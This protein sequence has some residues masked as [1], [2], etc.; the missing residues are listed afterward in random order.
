MHLADA[1]NNTRMAVPHLQPVGS[2]FVTSVGTYT[3]AGIDKNANTR[4]RKATG[5]I[6]EVGAWRL[7][8]QTNS[9]VVIGKRALLGVPQGASF[10]IGGHPEVKDEHKE[11]IY[12]VLFERLA[13]PFDQVVA[14]GFNAVC[15]GFAPHEVTL[16]LEDGRIYLRDLSPRPPQ[17]IDTYTVRR[18]SDG[19]FECT[20]R[21]IGDT[22][23]VEIVRYGQ[24]GSDKGWLWWP[25]YGDSGSPF[26]ESFYRPIYWVHSERSDALRYRRMAAQKSAVPMPAILID[27]NASIKP[28]DDDLEDAREAVGKALVHEEGV[29]TLPG[30]V[31][32]IK[33]IFG[34]VDAIEKL[35][36]LKNNCDVEILTLFAAQYA[37]RGAIT[38]H[39][40]NSANESDQS[41]MGAH[42]RM[43][44]QWFASQMQ[45]LI[46]WLIDQTF[47]PQKF[48]PC[49]TFSFEREISAQDF[50][51]SIVKAASVS[52]LITIDDGVRDTVRTKLQLEPVD[53][54]E[55]P[56]ETPADQPT[57]TPIDQSEEMSAC[58][59]GTVHEFADAQRKRPQPGGQNK[60]TGPN[61]REL[62]PLEK[63]V[64]YDRIELT[65]DRSEA[66]IKLALM[67]ARRDV[68]EYLR[69]QL[70]AD[71]SWDNTADAIRLLSNMD[72]PRNVT[73]SLRDMIRAELDKIEETA[74]D[75]I[76]KEFDRQSKGEP[77]SAMAFATEQLDLW[78][79]TTA[80]KEA[81]KAGNDSKAQLIEILQ[82]SVT[83]DDIPSRADTM[84][85]LN[86]SA[87]EIQP[88]QANAAATL[89]ATE[90]FARARESRVREITEREQRTPKAVWYSAILDSNTCVECEAADREYGQMTGTPIQWG[91]AEHAA[92][93]PPYQRC[94]GGARCR[95]VLVYEWE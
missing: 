23:S 16:F 58:D 88:A 64:P 95:C 86:T 59:C 45:P 41:E 49:L 83:L 84:R 50:I 34:Q 20:Q 39:G 90:T 89:A 9:A 57:E 40:T 12:Q 46:D 55:Q 61:G 75:T 4:G 67:D 60:R 14:S 77:A 56:T 94:L 37:A 13:R 71:T 62:S 17:T 36:E 28:S 87:D 22:G 43:F 19:W 68:M 1:C 92:M 63:L 30:W 7:M 38:G 15:Y 35:T 44:L 81:D 72:I 82:A 54:S 74:V 27:D 10:D 69:A 91:S 52:G 3:G 25:I 65:L 8:E 93:M 21:F 2:E 31:K 51:D 32:E 6:S 53:G 85:L 11:Y 33:P 42:R 76:D 24:P 79:D 29:F 73:A 47:G 48:Y 26:G 78:Q 70:A 66:A 18:G 80:T 5:T